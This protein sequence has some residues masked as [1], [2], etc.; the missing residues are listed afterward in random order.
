MQIKRIPTEMK[1]VETIIYTIIILLLTLSKG[2]AQDLAKIYLKS[3]YI[4]EGEIIKI[5]DDRVIFKEWFEDGEKVEYKMFIKYIYKLESSIGEIK[6]INLQFEEE[7]Y[8]NVKISTA[9]KKEQESKIEQET[10]ANQAFAIINKKEKSFPER[11]ELSLGL[12]FNS[13][14]IGRNIGIHLIGRN[15]TVSFRSIWA[16]ELQYNYMNDPSIPYHKNSDLVILY[17]KRRTD[18]NRILF[19]VGNSNKIRRGSPLGQGR[20]TTVKNSG[21]ALYLYFEKFL[22]NNSTFNREIDA[23]ATLNSGEILIGVGIAINITTE[24]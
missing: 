6:I 1:I 18:N 7:F 4:G 3:G 20:H 5:E 24:N 21:I 8:K 9:L 14:G 22:S 19:G 12:G 15:H 2:Y 13:L 23:Y 16:K 10:L 11:V 17:G